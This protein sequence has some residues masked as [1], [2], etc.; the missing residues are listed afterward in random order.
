MR[1]ND[2]AMCIEQIDGEGR[3]GTVAGPR[4]HASGLDAIGAANFA[5]LFVAETPMH[6]HRQDQ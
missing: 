6:P 1:G 5:A 2:P 4:Y 3:N